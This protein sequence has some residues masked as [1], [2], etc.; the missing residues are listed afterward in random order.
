M[1]TKQLI[2]RS[3][4]VALLAGLSLG[5][6]SFLVREAEAVIGA[7][8]TPFS[9]AGVARRTA[10]RTTA[11]AASASQQQASAAQQQA[12]VAKQEAAAAQQQAAA[13]KRETEAAKQELAAQKAAAAA[14]P[15]GTVVSTL[16]AGCTTA[17]IAG[18]DYFNCSGTYY[19]A[20]F[21]SN[22]VVYIVSQP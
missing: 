5:S 7:P 14:L 22:N 12:A 17:K 6:P 1:N 18:V 8:A 10:V 2:L 21:K 20:A 19:K 11:A 4:G 15:V 16:P 13:A 3:S 9:I